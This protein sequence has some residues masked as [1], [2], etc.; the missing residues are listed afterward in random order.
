RR[1][2]DTLGDQ[3][4]SSEIVCRALGRVLAEDARGTGVLRSAFEKGVSVYVP[5]FTDSELGLDV[6][7]WAMKSAQASGEV[8]DPLDL[9]SALPRYTPYLDLNSLARCARGARRLGIFT[10]GGGVPR[11]WAQEVGPYVDITTPRLGTSLPPPRYQYAV[12]LCPEP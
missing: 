6:S 11:N 5:A 8:R 10:V 7:T 3:L 2:L 4:L 12:R 1:A 9:F